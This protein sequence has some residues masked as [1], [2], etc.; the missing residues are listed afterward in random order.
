LDA[1]PEEEFFSAG[2]FQVRAQAEAQLGRREAARRSIDQAIEMDPDSP[3][4]IYAASVVYALIGEVELAQSFAN[5][6]LAGGRHPRWFDL[7]WFK[8]LRIDGLDSD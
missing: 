7:P 6:S 3:H 4:V 8:G 1:L 2:N 5:Q